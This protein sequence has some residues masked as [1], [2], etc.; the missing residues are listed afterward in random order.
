MSKQHTLQEFSVQ[1]AQNQQLGQAGYK[2]IKTASGLAA[3]TG[4]DHWIAYTVLGTAGKTQVTISGTASHS[5]DGAN[6]YTAALV[7]MGTTVYGS[8][9]NIAITRTG[10]AGGSGTAALIAYKG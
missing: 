10:G 3:S 9:K 4:E 7:P 1:E 2:Y 5:P 6:E 8:F